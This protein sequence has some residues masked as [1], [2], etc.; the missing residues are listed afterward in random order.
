M[1]GGDLGAA[2]I[3]GLAEALAG[4][5]VAGADPSLPLLGPLTAWTAA[6]RV[7]AVL[8]EGRALTLNRRYLDLDE[9]G[10]ERMA[11]LHAALTDRGVG[12]IVLGGRW[13]AQ[14]TRVL[15]RAFRGAPNG[16]RTAVIKGLGALRPPAGAMV[17]GPGDARAWPGAFGPAPMEPAARATFTY[18]R[19][20]ALAQVAL[21]A[22]REGRSLDLV[23]D[24]VALAL[25]D[26]IDGLREPAYR[27][28]LLALPLL[29]DRGVA[30]HSTNVAVLALAMGQLL[31]LDRSTLYELGFAAFFHDIGRARAERGGG[32]GA[33][34]AASAERHLLEGVRDCLRG[35]RGRAEQARLLGVT[36]HHVLSDGVPAGAAEP[37]AFAVLV[38]LADAYDLGEHGAP[39]ADAAAP[40]RV[41]Q[42]LAQNPRFPPAALDLLRSVLGD[43]PRGS[44]VRAA[45]GGVCLVV[46]GAAGAGAGVVARRLMNPNGSAADRALVGLATGSFQVDEV[47]LGVLG[48][49]PW[50]V[51]LG[52]EPLELP[53]AD[54]PEDPLGLDADPDPEELKLL[55]GLVDAF[56]SCLATL[57]E[58]PLE[59][60]KTQAALSGVFE[61]LDLALTQYPRLTLELSA[62]GICYRG[63]V[64]TP[65]AGGRP[66]LDLL[67][68]RGVRSLTFR[69][70]LSLDELGRLLEAL[71]TVAAGVASEPLAALWAVDLQ[72]VR[73]EAHDPHGPAAVE[74]E[75]D[76]LE[77]EVVDRIVSLLE[78]TPGPCPEVDAF[79]E[80][81]RGSRPDVP[82]AWRTLPER[83]ADFLAS[84]EGSERLLFAER[85]RQ[86]MEAHCLAALAR[87]QR[88]CSPD[89]VASFQESLVRRLLW[90]GRLDEA[91]DALE[92][93]A[94]DGDLPPAL[95]KRLSSERELRGLLRCLRR[96][97]DDP[98][99][100]GGV[101]YL[102]YLGPR[103]V[104]SV[105]ALY[106]RCSG[107]EALRRLLATFLVPHVRIDPAPLVPLSLAEDPQIAREALILMGVGGEKSLGY[108]LLQEFVRELEDPDPAVA[109][110][111]RVAKEVLA[112]A[113]GA[114]VRSSLQETV[115]RGKDK[116][117]RLAAAE[118]LRAVGTSE[119]Y[120]AL[121]EYVTSRA[122][123][124]RDDDEVGAVLETLVRLGE[125]R[126]AKLLEDLSRGGRF[127]L[128]KGGRRVA[129]AAAL[130]LDRLRRLR[131]GDKTQ[132]IYLRG[133]CRR[134]K[135]E[136]MPGAERCLQC[137][138]PLGDESGGA[139][140]VASSASPQPAARP[141]TVRLRRPGLAKK[142]ATPRSPSGRLRA[143]GREQGAGAEEA[144]AWLSYPLLPPVPLGPKP[145][146]VVGRAPGSDLELV[147]ESVS[148]EHAVVRVTPERLILEDRSSYGTWVNG[149]RTLTAD[150][151]PGDVLTIGPFDVVVE[152]ARAEANRLSDT[153]P[154][155]T[156]AS[157][158]AIGGRLE[159]VS[160]AEVLQ[161]IELNQK[162]GTLEVF[163]DDDRTGTLVIYEGRP[164]YAELAGLRDADAVLAML[165][166]A[167]GNFSFRAKVEAGEMTMQGV[168]LTGLLMEASRQMDEASLG[169]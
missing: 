93:I 15:A 126:A 89:E 156:F 52:S 33:E 144:R 96:D 59:H 17:L 16:P 165:R 151:R 166:L 73:W 79:C 40:A 106:A 90:E 141:A 66:L 100:G 136:N 13:D 34:E 5:G 7:A 83:S 137:G 31:D 8:V 117:A 125:G 46:D 48:F 19:L 135:F 109:L 49:K 138:S 146:V 155:R 45:G 102:N 104:E 169:E 160:L 51:A 105:C 75:S 132:R 71:A 10:I 32:E 153:R 4:T 69:Q 91:L 121:A 70:G 124:G 41:L 84:P 55:G 65:P 35:R 118:Q 47:D 67:R 145:V 50:R 77:A 107:E 131:E 37:H 112:E 99:V 62:E 147:H 44:F 101:A 154:L 39:W 88:A 20:Q 6:H 103:A 78:E 110:R 57:G 12:G 86:P 63:G 76:P 29:P 11:L 130:K 24:S 150:L 53:P 3:S 159:R 61:G 152:P 161:Q 94:G 92:T 164:M 134:C 111:A 122:F 167:K 56:L 114:D 163:T 108:G 139:V 14:A 28:R 158:E 30:G 27:R 148:R 119:T 64:V 120:D 18:V 23:S 115:V 140:Q 54:P 129:R 95:A 87:V 143:V 26:L 43:V 81:A 60:P 9:Q 38:E 1:S 149:K 74:A 72:H 21:E 128:G 22:A 116:A 80:A 98:D 142:S 162:T 168:T 58:F 42:N 127:S 157:S 82:A 97:G 123:Q 2:L 113:T 36:E 85:V 133:V 25:A 68:P